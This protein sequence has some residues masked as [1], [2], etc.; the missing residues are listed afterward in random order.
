MT[1]ILV[2]LV[3]LAAVVWRAFIR[4]M[5]VAEWS[6]VAF[7]GL[8]I[9]IVQLQ[10]FVGENGKLVWILRYHQA[11]LA[12]LYGWAAWTVVESVKASTGWL[13]K[14]IVCVA[15]LW[16]ASAGGTVLWRIVKHSF[17]ESRRNSQMLAA[18]WA[19]DVIEKDWNGPKAD[20]ERF[21]TIQEYH[22]RRRP[23]VFSRGAYLPYISGGRWYSLSPDVRRHETPDYAFLS[24][25]ERVPGGMVCIAEK[26]YG[27]KKR[28]FRIYRKKK[29]KHG[30]IKNEN[31]H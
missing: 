17:V 13:R 10:M 16:L 18:Q 4:K 2:L 3:A 31:K 22:P 9:F 28:V 30:K 20:R 25:G 11:A 7:V 14:G 24:A 8:N 29:P 26:T 23:V 6:L 19:A 15:V 5:T 1:Q 12:L 27:K 21:F